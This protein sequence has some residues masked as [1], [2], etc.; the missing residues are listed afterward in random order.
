VLGCVIRR[1]LRLQDVTILALAAADRLA[2]DL[3]IPGT[4]Y[5]LLS[6]GELLLAEHHITDQDVLCLPE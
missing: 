1:A 6:T 5:P 3:E 4:D 2:A